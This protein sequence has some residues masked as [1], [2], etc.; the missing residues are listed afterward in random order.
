LLLLLLFVCSVGRLVGL[1]DPMCVRDLEHSLPSLL[2]PHL[3]LI[4]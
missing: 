3:N 2:E 4:K 1:I